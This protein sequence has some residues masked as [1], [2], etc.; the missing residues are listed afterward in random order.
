MIESI[1]T[2][3]AIKDSGIFLVEVWKSPVMM[4]LIADMETGVYVPAFN[5]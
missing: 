3:L 5:L 4:E 2:P 1:Q